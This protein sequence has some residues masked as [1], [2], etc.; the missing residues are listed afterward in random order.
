[1]KKH[2][3]WIKRILLVFGILFIASTILIIVERSILKSRNDKP[4]KSEILERH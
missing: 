3:T 4:I 1:M 2:T